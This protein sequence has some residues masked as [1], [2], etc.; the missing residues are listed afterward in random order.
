MKRLIVSACTVMV[1]VSASASGQS[2]TVR[3]AFDD[4][5]VTLAATDALVTDVLAA[6][7]EVGGTEIT[8]VENVK[9]ARITVEFTAASEL[10]VLDELL[11]ATGGYIT[12]LRREVPAGSSLLRSIQIGL[13]SK[14]SKPVKAA[15]V[16]DMSIPE[17]QFEY[18]NP[19]PDFPD[20]RETADQ[21]PPAAPQGPYIMPEMRFQYAETP[22]PV[23]A[24]P[25]PQDPPQDQPQDKPAVD[26]ASKKKPPQ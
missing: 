26:P 13:R 3:I 2:Q 18:A 12:G 8:G 15:R 25:E 10:T 16:V 6:W 17:S 11:G 22:M 4:G 21:V 24:E 23:P 7:A 14:E 19:A 20:P 1:L 5:K 9:P